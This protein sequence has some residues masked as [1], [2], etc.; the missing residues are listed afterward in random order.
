MISARRTGDN[1]R[2]ARFI[3]RLK[4]LV[5]IGNFPLGVG[6]KNYRYY[7]FEWRLPNH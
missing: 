7:P 6:T 4:M 2:H 1:S 5:K 3:S